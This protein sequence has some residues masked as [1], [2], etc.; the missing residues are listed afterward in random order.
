ML[1]QDAGEQTERSHSNRLQSQYHRIFQEQGVVR[2]LLIPRRE[3]KK[4]GVSSDYL[5][6]MHIFHYTNRYYQRG[7]SVTV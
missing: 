5:V 2:S 4:S 3:E 1:L 7:K 6:K